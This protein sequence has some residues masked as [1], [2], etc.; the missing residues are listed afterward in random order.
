VWPRRRQNRHDA[1]APPNWFVGYTPT[2]VAAFYF[3]DN[4]APISGDASAVVWPR[5]RN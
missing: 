5:R 3:A 1:A 2:I 4:P